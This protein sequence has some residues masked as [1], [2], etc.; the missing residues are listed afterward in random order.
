MLRRVEYALLI[1]GFLLL[2]LYAAALSYRLFCVRWELISFKNIRAKTV[3]ASYAGT[4]RVA[5][6][7]LSSE[8]Q[9]HGYLN[10]VSEHLPRPLAVL[11]ITKVH[12]EAPVLEG[13]GELVLT[14]GL[15]H[16]VG[17]ARPGEV[18]N[19]GIAGHRDGFF[20]VL[21]ELDVGDSIELETVDHTLQYRI[22]QITTVAPT[23]IAVLRPGV[24]SSLTL[25]T[26]Y[27]FYFVGNAPRRYV[28]EARVVESSAKLKPPSL[29]RNPLDVSHNQQ[30]NDQ[31]ST[32]YGNDR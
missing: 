1:L 9:V 21:R 6:F 8:S 22:S 24:V 30:R 11:R 4:H 3:A 32:Q 5:D 13:T 15:G 25:I 19:V 16:I 29:E 7:S 18:G 17:T 28:V 20:R 23:E 14:R 2:S 10:S 27:P 12:L 31:D 26:C